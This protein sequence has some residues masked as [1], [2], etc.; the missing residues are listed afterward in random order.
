MRYSVAENTEGETCHEVLVF[1]PYDG[2][3][4]PPPGAS[5]SVRMGRNDEQGK[6]RDPID[7]GGIVVTTQRSSLSITSVKGGGKLG[8]WGGV[9]P[10]HLA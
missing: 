10:Y 4:H 2:T 9:N 6:I 3:I 5:V 8:Q 1:S 7:V